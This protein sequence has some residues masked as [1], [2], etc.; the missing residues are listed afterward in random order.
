MAE[1]HDPYAQIK[2]ESSAR[3]G[4]RGGHVGGDAKDRGVMVSGHDAENAENGDASR[5]TGNENGAGA[6]SDR[7]RGGNHRV[8]I[9]A[10]AVAAILI[11]LLV[12]LMPSITSS[13]QTTEAQA[14]MSSATSISGSSAEEGQI[15]VALMIDGSEAGQGVI[16]DGAVIV[17]DDASVYDVMVASGVPLTVKSSMGMGTYIS[18]IDGLMEKDQ[19]QTSGWLYSVNGNKAGSSCDAIKVADGDQVE[20]TWR[21]DAISAS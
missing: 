18:G 8:A 3:K 15:T 11:V 16:Y 7:K 4:N 9:I 17:P 6:D 19:A 12:V 13:I 2:K 10:M 21:L 14:T 20:W 1:G 5:S